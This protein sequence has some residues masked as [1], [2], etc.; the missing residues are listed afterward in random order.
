MQRPTKKICSW[1]LIA[2]ALLTGCQPIQ[3]YY[4]HD[5]GDLS[6]Y[7]D[8][9]TEIEYTDVGQEPLAE[10]SQ[11][12]APRTISNPQFEEFWDLTLE[13]AISI[14]LQNSK[15]IRTYGQV[16]QFG[17]IVGNAPE[18]LSAAPDSVATIYDPAIQET[19]QSG[20]EQ[21]LS[22]FDAVFSSTANWDSSDRKQNFPTSAMVV[23]R[24]R[25]CNKTESN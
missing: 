20:V 2:S 22:A 3:P 13:D 5:D 10:V 1:V 17:Q 18:R 11:A 25:I 6:H 12:H 16:R 23:N 21:A 15:V 24:T 19:G 4:L 9:A 8:A 14:T 7:L